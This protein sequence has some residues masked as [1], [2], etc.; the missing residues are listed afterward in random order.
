[1]TAVT[2]EKGGGGGGGGGDDGVNG[3]G[4]DQSNDQRG[5][6]QRERAEND[7]ERSQPLNLGWWP[8]ASFRHFFRYFAFEI[9][10]VH[11]L[12]ALQVGLVCS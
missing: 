7:F 5:N 6:E 11:P 2:S 12:T 4:N 8:E 1:M 9:P 3:Q 10:L